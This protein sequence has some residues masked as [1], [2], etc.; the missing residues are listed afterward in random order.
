M[1]YDV[2]GTL[3]EVC[4]CD[5]NCACCW[6]GEE[7]TGDS[8]DRVV[9]WQIEHGSVD[10]IDVS[11]VT[12]AMLGMLDEQGAPVKSMIFL[13]DTIEDDAAD[14]LVALWS[15]KKGGPMADLAKMLGDVVGVER[16]SIVYRDGG[17]LEI[18][19]RVA[20]EV[21]AG[22]RDASVPA[23]AY[24]ADVPEL[25]IN[26]SVSGQRAVHGAFHFAS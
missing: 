4:T 3:L 15:G 16:T 23:T 18:G 17:H 19:Q 9:A 12:L 22:A 5:V 25:G 11:G 10:G 6:T 24:R 7:P 26:L 2:K 20:A 1:G 13:P 21:P 14:A 8:C